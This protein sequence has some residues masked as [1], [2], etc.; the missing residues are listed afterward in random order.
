MGGFCQAIADLL[1]GDER[2]DGLARTARDQAAQ[3][4]V[5]IW[6]PA[7]ADAIEGVTRTAEAHTE[8]RLVMTGV[9]GA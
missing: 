4:D 5:S 6:A 9:E 7:W 2:R 1:A 8:H 3:F